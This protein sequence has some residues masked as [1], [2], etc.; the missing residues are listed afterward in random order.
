[1]REYNEAYLR[2]CLYEKD[3]IL[4]WKVRPLRHFANVSKW[5]M[6]NTKYAGLEAGNNSKRGYKR[7]NLSG[8][9]YSCHRVVFLLTQGYLPE[10]VDHKDTDKHH[11]GGTNLREAGYSENNQNASSHVDGSSKYKGVSWSK[12][13]RKWRAYCTDR[14]LGKTVDGT[15]KQRYVGQSTSEVE[16]ALLYDAAARDAFGE[17]AWL[18]CEHF[19]EVKNAATQ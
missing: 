16:A 9:Y 1:M 18:N 14:R 11:N 2:E 3:G 7:F 19:E 15:N 13:K 10:I 8:E 5:K 12:D 17:F 4:I 6:W